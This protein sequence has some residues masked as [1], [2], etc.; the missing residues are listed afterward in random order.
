MK[1]GTW[2]RI[3]ET[4]IENSSRRFEDW[5]LKS[6]RPMWRACT[7]CKT[8]IY[9]VVWTAELYEWMCS[10]IR[11]HT[12]LHADTQTEN[13]HERFTVLSA[14]VLPRRPLPYLCSSLSAS[15]SAPPHPPPPPPS[16]R[17][18]PVAICLS[19]CL[20]RHVCLSVCPSVHLCLSVCLSVCLPVSLSLSLSLSVPPPPPPPPPVSLSSLHLRWFPVD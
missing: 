5:N 1:A 15:V 10:S 2:S 17:P 9:R 6:H 7:M 18:Y 8:N 14:K 3:G 20:C 13:R 16:T 4:C 12:H 11:T 19:V